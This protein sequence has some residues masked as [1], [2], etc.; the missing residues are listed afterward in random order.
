MTPQHYNKKSPEQDEKLNP[1]SST[2]FCVVLFRCPVYA[3]MAWSVSGEQPAKQK[4][5]QGRFNRGLF[6]PYA[7]VAGSSPVLVVS[8]LSKRWLAPGWRCG[9]LIVHD[10]LGVMDAVRLGLG[11]FAF[12][13]Q[14]PASPIQVAIPTLLA[15]TPEAFFDETLVTLR[16]VGTALHA[17][18]SKI[19]GLNP[20]LPQGAMYLMCGITSNGRSIRET[21]PAFNDDR[22]FI[23]AFFN[24]ENVLVLPGACF[25]LTAYLRFVT[26][27]PLPVLLAACDRLE[28]FCARHRAPVVE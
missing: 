15:N 9:W 23:T 10:P 21:Y 5:V 28:V 11:R 6:T 27:V 8:A 22:E 17:R 4:N 7:T 26:T 20:L 24:E 3:G 18:L 2:D 12:R 14:G 25:R 19:E 16:D 1:S 13:I